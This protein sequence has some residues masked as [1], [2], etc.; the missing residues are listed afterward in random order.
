MI[1]ISRAP[2]WLWIGLAA[3][4]PALIIG[5]V[6]MLLY[7]QTLPCPYCNPQHPLWTLLPLLSLAAFVPLAAL[8]GYLATRNRQLLEPAARAGFVVGLCSAA[9]GLILVPP[10]HPAP[11]CLACLQYYAWWLRHW[12]V[13]TVLFVP[14][15]PA[16]F[17]SR[18][19]LGVLLAV[20]AALLRASPRPGARALTPA[21]TA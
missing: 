11:L 1:P 9:S 12:W 17:L 8:S 6:A 16:W 2:R 15:S 13:S 20:A 18:V 14:P 7:R 5:S 3:G 10:V 21:G 19:A 4:I